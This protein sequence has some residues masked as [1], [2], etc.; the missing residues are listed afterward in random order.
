MS[1]SG[2]GHLDFIYETDHSCWDKNVIGPA[3][4]YSVE[5]VGGASRT[6]GKL[7][8]RYKE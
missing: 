2:S 5:G 4:P 6:K 3:D 7:G 1:V 8:A